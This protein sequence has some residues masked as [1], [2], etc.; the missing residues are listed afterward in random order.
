MQLNCILLFTCVKCF[1]EYSENLT[2]MS[3]VIIVVIFVENFG[4]DVDAVFVGMFALIRSAWSK[5]D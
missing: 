2:V 3:W 5:L 1:G 4:K